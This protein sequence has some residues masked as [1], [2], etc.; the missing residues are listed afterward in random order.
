MFL[1]TLCIDHGE[2]LNID[3]HINRMQRTA[4]HFGFQAPALPDLSSLLHASLLDTK[5]KCRILYRQTLLDI[6]FERY[7]PKS[8]R[9]LQ[10]V[11]AVPDYLF[12]Y[13]DR[14]ELTSLLKHKGKADEIL[15]TRNGL[16]TDTTFSNVVLR[17]G[18]LFFTP[19]SWLLNGTKRQKLLREG[20]ITERRI[21]RETLH[22]YE[23][24]YLINAMLDIDDAVPIPVSS[25]FPL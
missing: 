11:E 17:Q 6:S 21:T 18:D 22:E 8:V 3:G 5:V 2:V 14:E 7:Q 4:I 23:S 19:D 10:L 20:I 15:I 25:I 12:K 16:I 1:E 9:S 24:V 13:A